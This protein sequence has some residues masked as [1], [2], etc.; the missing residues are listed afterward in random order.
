MRLLLCCL[1]ALLLPPPLA[2]AGLDLGATRL[3]YTAGQ[4]SAALRVSNPDAHPVLVQAWV[5]AG[6]AGALPETIQTPFVVT[7]PL[8]RIDA[9]R[10][11]NLLVRVAD[12]AALPDDREV[13]YRLNIV[14]IP[15]LPDTQGA[16]FQ[17]N[18]HS[19]IK[20][21]YRPAGLRGQPGAAPGQLRWSVQP[22]A[23]GDWQLKVHNPASYGVNIASLS[24]EDGARRLE[25]AHDYLPPL[26]DTL[27]ALP[28]GNGT[29][30]R[31]LKIDLQWI[32][33]VGAVHPL[34]ATAGG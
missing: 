23:A 30:S 7:P 12:P 33:D 28:A 14:E 6:D 31:A 22:T 25:L 10:D 8:Q 20:L 16:R 11:R 15:A 4:G 3:I 2:H 13:V 17:V 18:T 26:A 1:L 21:L 27:I 9:G 34:T 32:D 19:R 5:D 24:L 29:P